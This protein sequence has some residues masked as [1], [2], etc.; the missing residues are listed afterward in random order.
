[1]GSVWTPTPIG[2]A[3]RY[4]IR[5][6]DDL[7]RYCD[8]GYLPIDNNYIERVIRKFVIGR[9]GWLFNSSKKGAHSLAVLYSLVLS[10]RNLDIC[11]FDYLTDVIHQ[12]GTLNRT[13]YFNLTPLAWKMARTLS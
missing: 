13:D 2:K 12:I 7:V 1:M 4:Y 6:Y 5:L 8:T 3:I 9:K 10:C 11:P